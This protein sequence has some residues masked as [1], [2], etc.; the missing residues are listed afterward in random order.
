M[1]LSGVDLAAFIGFIAL[2]VIAGL[3]SAIA[4][5]YYLR[6]AVPPIAPAVAN[7]IYAATG[8]RLRKLPIRRQDLQA[9]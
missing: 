3:N 6:L 7:A 1:A 9:P 8:L 5:F 2:V 4:A